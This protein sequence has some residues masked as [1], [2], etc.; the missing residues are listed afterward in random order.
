MANVS[1]V[2]HLMGDVIKLEQA[3]GQ[4]GMWKKITEIPKIMNA[5]TL[6]PYLKKQDL[7]ID[8]I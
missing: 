5:I 7:K 3:S 4:H 2:V 1:E 8:K 6:D